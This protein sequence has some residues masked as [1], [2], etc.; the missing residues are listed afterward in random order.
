MVIHH[1][2]GFKAVEFGGEVPSS[3][4][5]EQLVIAKENAGVEVVGICAQLGE[6]NL[7]NI[8]LLYDLVGLV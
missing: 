8:N 1:Y 2:V 3:W 7:L 4:S 5:K 6:N